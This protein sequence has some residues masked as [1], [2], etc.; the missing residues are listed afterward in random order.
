MKY[1]IKLYIVKLKWSFTKYD[2]LGRIILQ[3][4]K[5]ETANRADLQNTANSSSQ[6][7]YENRS[8]NGPIFYSMNN[9]FPSI[10][11][12]DIRTSIYY[13]GLSRVI[14]TYSH[15]GMGQIDRKDFQYNFVG[16]L[17]KTRCV[18]TS[19]SGQTKSPITKT[20]MIS[21]MQDKQRII[22]IMTTEV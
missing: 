13:D 7:A 4:E 20:S 12:S 19:A 9:A 14:Q 21:E 6:I 2:A 1:F 3:G 10:Q 15:N 18:W 11:E 8:T 22:P 16:E 5:S 17:L